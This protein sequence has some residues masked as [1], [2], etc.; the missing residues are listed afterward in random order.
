MAL[1]PKQELFIKEYLVDLN[2]TQAAI[3]AGY[4]EKTAKVI[5]H[6][7]LTKPDIRARIDE[8]QNQRAEKVELDAEWVLR[9][10][11]T[12]VER[13]LQAVP[14]TKWDYEEKKLLETGEYTF[15]SSGANRA[16]E[17]VG[18]HLGMFKD[19]LELSGETTFVVN[20]KRVKQDATGSD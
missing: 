17:L 3:R 15:D 14:V 20:R 8:L 13:S 18:K 10:L 1:T 11:Q 19:K 2:A 16:L 5:G 9:N 4:S 12:V 7:N 6:E